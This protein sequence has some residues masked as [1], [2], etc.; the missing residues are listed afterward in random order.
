MPRAGVMAAG[1]QEVYP[2]VS[3][4]I[5]RS[6]RCTGNPGSVL[7]SPAINVWQRL[8]VCVKKTYR[9]GFASIK[10]TNSN[11][12]N[13]QYEST[14]NTRASPGRTYKK[15]FKGVCRICDQKGHKSA[16]C[17]EN[18]QHK[19]ERPA[20]WKIKNSPERHMQS[21]QIVVYI[22]IL[23]TKQDTQKTDISK[24]RGK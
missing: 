24:R 19:D 5:K 8:I 12:R 11:T 7:Q 17:W 9:T 13:R 22:V 15:V 2:L 20:N 3:W 16:G 1:T 23:V 10:Q 4:G 18:P 14:L 6:Q 21:L